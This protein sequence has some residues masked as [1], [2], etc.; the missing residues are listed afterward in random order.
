VFRQYDHMVQTNTVVPPGAD[1]AVLRIKE[2]PARGLALTVDGNGRH[3]YLDPRI[4]GMLAVLE[5]AQNLACVGAAPAA[6]TDCLNFASPE[7]PEVFW[8]FREAVDGIARACEAL[9]I[10]VVGGNVSFYNEA[11][12]AI[13]PTPIVAMLGV[14][15]DVRQHATLGWRGD[16]DL[17]VLLGGGVP[18][19]DGSEYMATIH[20]VVSGRLRQPDLVAAASLIECTREAVAGRVVSS[21]HDCADGGIA[22]ALAECCIAGGR[23][24]TVALCVGRGQR[25]DAVLFGEGVGRII[26]S[27]PPSRLCALLLLAGRLAV[28]AQVLGTVGGDR[29]IVGADGEGVYGPWIDVPVDDLTRAWRGTQEPAP[30]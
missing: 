2:A 3:C 12:G 9:A 17:V 25:A 27:L 15:K 13:Y 29:L 10:P 21:A 26:V 18:Y 5:G 8:T 6:V 11:R 24:A 30:C 14:M 16:G 22:V 19:L 20:G 7:R 4:G 23:G 28:P 1:A